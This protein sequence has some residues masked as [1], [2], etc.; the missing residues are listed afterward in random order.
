M[1][2]PEFPCLFYLLTGLYCPGC[3]G[4]RS[5]KAM[6]HGQFLLAVHENPAAPLLVLIG[7]LW[8]AELLFSQN[9]KKY[10]LY[11]RRGIFWIIFLILWILWDILRNLIPV[12][13][14][15]T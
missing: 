3:G 2:I 8:I 14:P 9:G 12:L 4:T 10:T 15:F 7:T 11:P 5:V 13:Q 1:K 6:I